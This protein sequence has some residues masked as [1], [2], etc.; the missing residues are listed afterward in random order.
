MDSATGD[1]RLELYVRSLSGGEPTASEQAQRVR[2]LAATGRV[3]DA[4]VLV[5]GEEVGLST[6]AFRTRVGKCI[7]DRVASFRAWAQERGGSMRPFFDARTVTGTITGERYSSLRLPVSCLAEYE[8]GDLVH[9][10]PY[11]AGTTTCTVGE[12]LRHHE[13]PAGEEKAEG[14]A[15]GRPALH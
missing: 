1:R 6:T 2:N 12:R 5:W 8:D 13:R 4:T 7:L 14:G 10:A 11:R 3:A 9:V 15:A